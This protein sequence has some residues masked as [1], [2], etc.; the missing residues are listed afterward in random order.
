MELPS[1]GIP[2]FSAFNW[3]LFFNTPVLIGILVIYS[4]AYLTV[5][6]VL[7]YHWSVYGMR[8]SGIL[9]AE[10]LF[11]FVSL[12]LFVFAGLAITYF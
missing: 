6:V 4:A 1:I 3:T 10:T 11:L 9:V 5:T 2:A 7:I 8:S 12:I